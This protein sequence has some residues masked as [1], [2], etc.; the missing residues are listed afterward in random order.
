MLVHAFVSFKLDYCNYLLYDVPKYILK[1][2]QSVQNVAARLI[3]FS[4]K[5]DLIILVLFDVHW[6]PVNKMSVL[7]SRSCCS[8]SRLYANKYPSTFKI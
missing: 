1:K 6:L 5:Y 8:P 3:T 4:H 2:L 7:N